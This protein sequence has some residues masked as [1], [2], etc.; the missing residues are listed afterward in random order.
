[1]HSRDRIEA[2]GDGSVRLPSDNGPVL[3]MYGDGYP[4]GM[5]AMVRR[6]G[7]ASG[8]NAVGDLRVT[9]SVEALAGCKR[10][11]VQLREADRRYDFE[12]PGPAAPADARAHVANLGG[13]NRSADGLSA[14]RGSCARARACRSPRRTWTTCSSRIDGD[15]VATLEITRSSNKSRTT[16]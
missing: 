7:Q 2:R 1:V 5:G 14:P 13:T 11:V 3:D 16:R 15:I 6:E 8:Q 10:V 4:D 12:L 9:G